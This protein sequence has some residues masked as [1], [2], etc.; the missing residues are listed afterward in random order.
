MLVE[1]VGSFLV[2]GKRQRHFAG[3]LAVEQARRLEIC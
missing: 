3:R 1:K 2:G